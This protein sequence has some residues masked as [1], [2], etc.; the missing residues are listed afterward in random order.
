MITVKTSSFSCIGIVMWILCLLTFLFIATCT[1]KMENPRFKLNHPALLW[2]HQDSESTAAPPCPSYLMALPLNMRLLSGGSC[3][4]WWSVQLPSSFFPRHI[5][6]W[7]LKGWA[8]TQMV[9]VLDCLE[10]RLQASMADKYNSNV[11]CRN[12]FKLLKCTDISME[13]PGLHNSNHDR[14]EFSLEMSVPVPVESNVNE[15]WL[16]RQEELAAILS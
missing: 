4:P 14:A 8:L 12:H 5:L 2:H 13:I 6:C 16:F 3:Q 10:S 15:H 1:L 7:N 9:V 11:C